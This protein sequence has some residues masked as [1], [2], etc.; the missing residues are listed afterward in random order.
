[1]I[2]FEGATS[3]GLN[4]QYLAGSSKDSAALAAAVADEIAA[5]PFL[6]SSEVCRRFT[7]SRQTLKDIYRIIRA[8]SEARAKFDSSPFL[9][10]IKTIEFLS[11]DWPRTLQIV[12]GEHPQRPY[13]TLE[14]F[15]S[16]TCNVNCVF[17]YRRDRD[18]GDQRILSTAEFVS[19]VNEFADLGGTTLDVSGGLEPLLSPAIGSVLRTGLQRRLQ[20]N[21][22][23]IGNALHS[24]K[25]ADVLPHLSKIRV[26]L[27]AHDRESYRQ[28]MGV[29]QFD[30][31]VA[32]LRALIQTRA[33]CGT[34]VKIGISYVVT[35]GNF[36]N[37]PN[38]VNVAM[39]LGVDFLDLRS[40]S[41]P[42]ISNYTPCQRA[43]LCEILATVRQ[44]Q[45]HFKYGR[46]KIS[47]ADTF[48]IITSPESEPLPQVE[49]DLVSVLV[50]YRVT[51]TPA[52]KVVPLNILGQPTHEDDRFVLGTVGENKPLAPA[53]KQRTNI[54]LV[55][56]LP[57]LLLPHDKTLILALAKLRDD[58]KFGIGPEEG[59]FA[60]HLQ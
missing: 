10:L 3:G 44:G 31:V 41:A 22:Y 52:G 7:I 11:R 19:I 29:D 28:M 6:T 32:N 1:V 4:T 43:E 2:D 5:R 8:S 50:H 56:D 35:P 48:G 47:I 15:I 9:Y 33:N 36:G 17:C 51:V 42:A 59:P 39:S 25:L 45:A 34:A 27:N 23:T 58:L 55:P 46:L 16:G 37:I 38:M 26:S 24:A 49:P 30:R 54:P 13:E 14:L 53:I 60:V 57:D 21:L 40:A 12:R 18:Y 20:I